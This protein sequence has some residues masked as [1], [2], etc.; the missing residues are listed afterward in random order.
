MDKSPRMKKLLFSSILGLVL[1]GASC[2][3][4]ESSQ[5]KEKVETI[6]SSSSIQTSVNRTEIRSAKK[7]END[8]IAQ[9]S[10]EGNAPVKEVHNE[11]VPNPKALDSIKNSYPKKQ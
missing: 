2:S 5:S 3:D 11:G 8:S 10:N 7:L 4:H 9:E 6:D 1:M